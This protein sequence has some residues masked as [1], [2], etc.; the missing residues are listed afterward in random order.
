MDDNRDAY[1][2]EQTRA[3]GDSHGDSG[4]DVDAMLDD[5]INGQ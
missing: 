2:D 5:L 1:F 3:S 4:L